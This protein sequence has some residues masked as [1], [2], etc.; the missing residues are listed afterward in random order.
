[1]VTTRGRVSTPDFITGKAALSASSITMQEWRI[2]I[3][4]AVERLSINRF[5]GFERP[6]DLLSQKHG[7]LELPRR[8]VPKSVATA[9]EYELDE[10]LGAQT[11]FLK[12]LD[13][14]PM[15]SQKTWPTRQEKVSGFDGLTAPVD[16]SCTTRSLVLSRKKKF[17]VLWADWKR[18]VTYEGVW[19]DVSS[20][21]IQATKIGIA[22]TELQE[23]LFDFWMAN[24]L[25]RNPGYEILL[26]LQNAAEET[27]RRSLSRYRSSQAESATIAGYVNRID[28]TV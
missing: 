6:R 23:E 9:M 10:T 12:L 21:Y 25:K 5:D 15:P 7:S 18:W 26:T 16:E 19:N 22:H 24:N 14:E 27:E 1:M 11:P 20:I 8:V 4:S 13:L 28:I 17:Y 3:E 2:I